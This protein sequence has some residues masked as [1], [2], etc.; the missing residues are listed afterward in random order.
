[1]ETP[2]VLARLKEYPDAQAAYRENGFG[3]IDR[4]YVETRGG[5]PAAALY[6]CGG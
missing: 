6:L 1:M 3:A 2:F 5:G 4:A